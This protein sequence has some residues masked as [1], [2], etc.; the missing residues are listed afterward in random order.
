MEKPI[1]SPLDFDGNELEPKFIIDNINA[2]D[3]VF[4]NFLILNSS[5]PVE[6]SNMNLKNIVL[7]S[8]STSY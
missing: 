3:I 2:D 8:E 5:I 1:K 7:Y 6:V 4:Q